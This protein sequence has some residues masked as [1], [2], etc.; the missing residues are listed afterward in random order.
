MGAANLMPSAAELRFL[1]RVLQQLESRLETIP[2]T[3]VSSTSTHSR[4]MEGIFLLDL[5]I[6][7]GI[8][9][10]R[11]DRFFIFLF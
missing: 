7:A 2:L 9:V 6:A 1:I 4:D 11:V 3:F 10:E 5:F 8:A